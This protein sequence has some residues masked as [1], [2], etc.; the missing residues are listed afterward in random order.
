MDALAQL[1]ATA[2]YQTTLKQQKDQMRAAFLDACVIAY[3]GGLF[4]LTPEFL[5]GLSIRQTHSAGNELWVMDS[6]QT[7]VLVDVVE[8]LPKATEQYNQAVAEFGTRWI[9]VKRER[10]VTGI[11]SQ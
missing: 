6:N 3:R 9:A 10:T 7:P 8:F 11:L 2:N 1:L 5:S 4:E